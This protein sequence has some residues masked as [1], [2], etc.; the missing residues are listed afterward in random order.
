VQAIPT[1]AEI[2]ANVAFPRVVRAAWIYAWVFWGGLPLFIAAAVYG[3]FEHHV[4]AIVVAALLAV[5]NTD[6]S[7]DKQV[8]DQAWKL[9]KSDTTP[10]LVR[11]IPGA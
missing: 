5:G 9:A 11:W 8:R 2:R 10:R 4:W 3:V 6:I 7:E 1:E